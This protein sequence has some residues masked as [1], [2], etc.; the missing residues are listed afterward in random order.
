MQYKINNNIKIDGKTIRKYYL[1]KRGIKCE[2]CNNTIW[3]DK[4]IPVDIHHI[5]G[6]PLNNR[7]ENIKILCPNC[8]TQ[9]D[10]YKSKN[11]KIF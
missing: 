6:N 5:D 9:T 4:P 8:H 11:R 1:N 2:Q 10:N 3:N 7:S